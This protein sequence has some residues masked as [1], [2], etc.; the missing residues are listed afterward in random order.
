MRSQERPTAIAA[1]NVVKKLL[2]CMVLL[3]SCKFGV[4]QQ[5]RKTVVREVLF[6]RHFPGEH[7]LPAA[8]DSIQ[9]INVTLDHFSIIMLPYNNRADGMNWPFENYLFDFSRIL[10]FICITKSFFHSL[11]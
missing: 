3:L 5:E 8:S 2:I 4:A 10:S 9:N 7:R 1:R 6:I 11:F